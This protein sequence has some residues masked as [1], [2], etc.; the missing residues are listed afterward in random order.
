M[1]VRVISFRTET[2]FPYQQE[3]YP[4]REKVTFNQNY[5]HLNDG[6]QSFLIKVR[7]TLNNRFISIRVRITSNE[8]EITFNNE[9]TILVPYKLSYH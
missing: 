7:V 4:T 2:K 8:G 6:S 3:F 5:G 1:R 9:E